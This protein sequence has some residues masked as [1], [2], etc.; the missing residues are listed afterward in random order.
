[1]PGCL[2]PGRRNLNAKDGFGQ[3]K[4]YEEHAPS[5]LASSTLQGLA[6]NRVINI[7]SIGAWVSL[8]WSAMYCASKHALH[9]YTRSLHHEVCREG[10]HVMSVVPGIVETRFR[11]QVIGGHAPEG[12]TR[13]KRTIYPQSLAA[14]IA[15]GLV[16]GKHTV[17]KPRIGWAFWA[18]EGF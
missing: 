17:V 15:D 8:P 13:I 18:V 14:S 10:I 12:V 9:A 1:M 4:A 3:R 11:A 7:E 5:S 16:K 2:P 6:S